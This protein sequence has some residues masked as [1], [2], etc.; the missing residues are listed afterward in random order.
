MRRRKQKPKKT[1]RITQTNKKAMAKA[2][3]G[4]KSEG[5]GIAEARRGISRGL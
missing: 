3:R 1:M 2:G 5:S 4:V